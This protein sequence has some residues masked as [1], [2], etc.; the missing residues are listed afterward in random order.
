MRVLITGGGGNLGRVLAPALEEAG[1]EP[2]LMDNRELETAHQMVR[3]DVRDETEVLQ[4]LRDVS[5]VVHAAALH[6]IHLERYTTDGFWDL[7]VAG[8]RNIYEAARELGI[9]KILLCSTMG[10]HGEGVREAGDPPLLTEDL[11][12]E[13]SD[14]YGL[15]K[16]LCEELAAYYYRRDGIRR[17]AYRLGMFVPESFVG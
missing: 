16:R 14:Y 12:L 7:N 15:T 17:I 4:D 6:G 1:Y 9:G 10:V 2:I 11:S 8:T 3:G 5:V 13:P